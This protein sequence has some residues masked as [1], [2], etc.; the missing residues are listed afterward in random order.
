M[1]RFAALLAFLLCLFSLN[2]QAAPKPRLTVLIVVDQMRADYLQ[3]FGDFLLP[4][5]TESQPGGFAF[6]EQHGAHFI[7]ARYR[8]FPLFTGPGHAVI[9]T[10]GYPYKNGIIG[11]D[12]YSK[13]SQSNVYCVQDDSAR[14]VGAAPGSK[15][16]PMSPRNLLST[17]IGDELK[18][19]T[20]GAARVVSVSLKDRAAILMG[21]RLADS[22]IWFDASTG[23]WI[24]SDAY[25]PDNRLPAWVEALNARRVP[26]SYFGRVWNATIDARQHP[27]WQAKGKSAADY[28]D[29][30]AGYGTQFPH[31]INGGLKT[32]G[33]AFYQAFTLTPWANQMVLDAAQSAIQTQKMGADATPDLLTINLASNDYVGHAFGPDSP[34]VREITLATD[35]SLSQFF[36]FI[37]NNVPGGLKN[38]IIALTAD[39]G[40]AP[41]PQMMSAAGFDAGRIENKALES[42]AENAL[43]RQ[44]GA[45][46]WVLKYVEPYLYLNDAAIANAHQ[47]A[48]SVQRAAARALESV[49]GVYAAYSRAQ[50]EAGQL[51]ATDIGARLSKAFYPKRAGD[52]LLIAQSGW[53]SEG[54]DQHASTHGSPYLYDTHVPILL[55]GPGVQIGDYHQSVGPSDLAPTLCDLM[56]INYPSACDG[57]ALPVFAR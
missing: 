25:C 1:L 53:F 44:F 2:A 18:M 10:G 37:Q 55:F 46:N 38:V 41:I 12:W 6:L 54:S 32:P 8:H 15:A 14:V 24:S 20:G 50:I 21:G 9:A 11:N 40:V 27:L 26:D 19:A 49:E 48:A 28:A 3:R 36:R 39:H 7:D 56:G 5:G 31:R 57:H 17:T 13:A 22:A 16:R 42:A 29:P 47:D 43:D 33:A 4:A 45:Q 51:P 34:E 30:P 23:R 52:V 35:R